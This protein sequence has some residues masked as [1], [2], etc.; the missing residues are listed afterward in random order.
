M[1]TLSAATTNAEAVLARIDS[2]LGLLYAAAATVIESVADHVALDEA[3]LHHRAAALNAINRFIDRLEKRRAAEAPKPEP[4]DEEESEQETW[5]NAYLMFT[6]G[7]YKK[8]LAHHDPDDEVYMQALRH[9]EALREADEAK[10]AAEAAAAASS[11]ADISPASAAPQTHPTGAAPSDAEFPAPRVSP[12][13]VR[14]QITPYAGD[15]AS[16]DA[17]R[18]CLGWAAADTDPDDHWRPTA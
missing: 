1:S 18:S 15:P 13:H 6:Y 9:S 7:K 14:A 12:D 5:K 16:A 3:P 2:T 11:A 17:P 8:P 4:E 10:M